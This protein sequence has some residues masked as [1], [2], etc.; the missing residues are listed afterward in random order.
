MAIRNITNEVERMRQAEKN[1][2]E[3]FYQQCV[4]SYNGH[5]AAIPYN[6]II[7]SIFEACGVDGRG[8]FAKQLKSFAEIIEQAV[9]KNKDSNDSIPF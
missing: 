2:A 4:G 1:L 8:D 9:D 7:N 5:M 6:P 3:L